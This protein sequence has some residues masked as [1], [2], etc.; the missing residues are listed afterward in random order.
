MIVRKLIRIIYSCDIGYYFNPPPGIKF[1]HSALGVVIH[2]NA[3]I[4]KNVLIGHNVTIGNT[5]GSDHPPVIGNNCKIYTGSI[6][7][8]HVVIGN[9]SIIAAG[10]VLVNKKFKEKS[11]IMGTQ[12]NMSRNRI[13]T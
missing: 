10:T 9:D 5:T 3:K 2:R 6:L 4:G 8:G 1:G 12:G 13:D 7:L 11:L